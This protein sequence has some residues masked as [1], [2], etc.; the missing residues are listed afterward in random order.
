MLSLYNIS[1]DA[2]CPAACSGFCV[3]KDSEQAL[4][5]FITQRPFCHAAANVPAVLVVIDS[6][7]VS[8]RN[9]DIHKLAAADVDA[10]TIAHVEN[11]QILERLRTKLEC[12][13]ASIEQPLGYTWRHLA[14]HVTKLATMAE[15]EIVQ[16]LEAD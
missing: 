8:L 9:V 2:N 14:S 1:C 4:K 7:E 11:L 13:S 6:E 10:A 15:L 12:N 5:R 3:A 16:V